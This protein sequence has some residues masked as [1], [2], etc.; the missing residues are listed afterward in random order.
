MTK[1]IVLILL[2]VPTLAG[3]VVCAQEPATTEAMQRRIEELELQLSAAQL[4]IDELN[5]K[6]T[7]MSR[8]NSKPNEKSPPLSD[9]LIAGAEFDGTYNSG[10]R[11]GRIHMVISRR[12][13]N[14]VFGKQSIILEGTDLGTFDWEGR[15]D[16]NV[17][18]MNRVGAAKTVGATLILKGDSL[19]GMFRDAQGNSGRIGMPCPVPAAPA[20][21][22]VP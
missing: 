11:I 13:G 6:I 1:L 19:E 14:K 18:K 12:E 9:R 3:N 10:Q 2:I 20:P 4:K 5:K 7:E 8:R 22:L 16:A 21:I 15:I 17:F